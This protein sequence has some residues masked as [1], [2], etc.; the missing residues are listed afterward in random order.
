VAAAAVA[1][2]P[3]AL[4]AWLAAQRWAGAR[5]AEVRVVR[6]D[7]IPL[8]DEPPSALLL[9]DAT[10]G[11][12]ASVRYLLPVVRVA[13]DAATADAAAVIAA[14]ADGGP[15]LADA[16]HD[17]RFRAALLHALAEG[18]TFDGDG[19]RLTLQPATGAGLALE[20][21]LG[22]GRSRVI[23]GE[24]SNTSIV[25][26]DAVILKLY[27]RVE[28][29][30]H[31]DVEI[32]HFLSRRDFPHTPR[33]LG[34]LRVDDVRGGAASVAGM[35]QALVQG[36]EDVWAYALASARAYVDGPAG[37]G[38]APSPYGE[39]AARLGAVTRALHD[40]LASAGDDPE[41]APRPAGADDVARWAAGARASVQGAVALLAERLDAGLE[42]ELPDDARDVARDLTARVGVVLRDV[43][44][45]AASVG[46]DA[47]A[48]VRHHGD[49]HL[50]QLLRGA[51][52]ALYVIDFEGEPARPQ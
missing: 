22:A 44:A 31:P 4:G 18:H 9:V 6:L 7:V 33:L 36:A 48:T 47:G 32:T 8:F 51:E 26:G 2:A 25:Y 16:P 50:G 23:S 20:S 41:F 37:G 27:R 42:D 13:N 38:G 35:A 19:A 30:E 24:Q 28:P 10:L 52:G 14:R 39:E 45:L 40:A 1:L 21:A 11:A 46:D 17:E 29:G 5:G 12:D 49:Y 43:D 15:A 3:D 34:L